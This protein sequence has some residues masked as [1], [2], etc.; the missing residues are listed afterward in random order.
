MQ[1]ASP[2]TSPTCKQCPSPSPTLSASARPSP[3]AAAHP[4]AT[5]G[6]QG[7]A[8]HV[9]CA[10]CV[11]MSSA[12]K[13]IPTAGRAC[14]PHSLAFLAREPRSGPPLSRYVRCRA[15]A[16]GCARLRSAARLSRRRAACCCRP[17][18]GRWSCGSWR[19]SGGCGALYV[20][21]SWSELSLVGF[22][23]LFGTIS[24]ILKLP[25]GWQLS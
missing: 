18:T 3:T 15:P 6:G 14:A 19:T 21:I 12:L 23:C 10:C 9:M 7:G 24:C 5:T 11:S 22:S 16:A 20:G 8:Q 13:A 1:A 4:P 25:G 2:W 17:T